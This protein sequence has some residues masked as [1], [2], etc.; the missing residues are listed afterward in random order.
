VESLTSVESDGVVLSSQAANDAAA[1]MGTSLI[2]LTKSPVSIDVLGCAGMHFL[3]RRTPS[4]VNG[5]PLTR[6]TW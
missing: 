2:A 5:R 6:C 1:R 3:R 4:V